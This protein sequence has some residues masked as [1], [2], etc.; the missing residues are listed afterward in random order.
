MEGNE[1]LQEVL[2]K[3]LYICQCL[4]A[5]EIIRPHGYF[6]TKM[7]DLFTSFSV[8]LIFLMYLCFDKSKLRFE[9]KL[10]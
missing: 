1:N 4:M 10:I 3:Q 8:G 5:L 9:N 6:V 7:F 2:S